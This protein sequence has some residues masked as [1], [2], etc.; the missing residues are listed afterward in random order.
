MGLTSRVLC[1]LGRYLEGDMRLL[2][3]EILLKVTGCMFYAVNTLF[4][5]E[6][7]C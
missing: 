1:F 7:I 3:L 5:I 6:V 2:G 4:F